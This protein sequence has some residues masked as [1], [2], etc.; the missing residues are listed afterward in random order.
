MNLVNPLILVDGT[1]YLFRAFNALPEMR[2]SRGFPTHAIRGVV[3][4]LRKLVRDNP[5]ATVVVIF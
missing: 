3:M 1:Q 2:T 4:M 5:T